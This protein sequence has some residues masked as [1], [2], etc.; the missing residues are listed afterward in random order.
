MLR[1]CPGDDI[2]RLRFS[3]RLCLG[4]APNKREQ[5]RLTDLLAHEQAGSV[6]ATTEERQLDAWTSVARVLLNLDEFITRE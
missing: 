3:F 5:Q 6:A 1:E 4:R 2:T